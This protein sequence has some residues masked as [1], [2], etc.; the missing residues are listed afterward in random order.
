MQSPFLSF[1]QY[2]SGSMKIQ[3]QG[4]PCYNPLHNAYQNYVDYISYCL[5]DMIMPNHETRT[6]IDMTALIEALNGV[7]SAIIG[8]INDGAFQNTK[9]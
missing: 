8:E 9:L 4:M 7:Q 1:D 3:I 5:S 6:L 2:K